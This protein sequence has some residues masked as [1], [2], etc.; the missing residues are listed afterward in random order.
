MRHIRLPCDLRPK[1][2]Y[3][4]HDSRLTVNYTECD[5]S[6]GAAVGMEFMRNKKLDV[7]IGAPCQ[8][9]KLFC[10]S[11]KKSIN[12]FVAMEVMATM[13]TFYKTPLLAWGLVT[14]SKFTDADRYPY[15]TNIMANSL[16]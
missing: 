13:A 6:L 7:V 10:R 14:D 15:L 12:N 11:Q 2:C 1:N 4:L 16:S 8:D 5:R 3:D 9:R